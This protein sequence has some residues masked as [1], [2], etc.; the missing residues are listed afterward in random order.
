M[1]GVHELGQVVETL[2]AGHHALLLP[3]DGLGQL[4]DVILPHLLKG[5]LAFQTLQRH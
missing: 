4:P 1:H 5:A 3:V 2:R